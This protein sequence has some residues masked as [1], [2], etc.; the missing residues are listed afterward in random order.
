MSHRRPL[1]VPSSCSSRAFA[2]LRQPSVESSS[3]SAATIST[4]ASKPTG[5]LVDSAMKLVTSH[6]L[7]DSVN[8]WREACS[9]VTPMLYSVYIAYVDWKEERRK[10]AL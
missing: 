7:E 2:A 4:A 8:D 1:L 5:V 3:C 6:I 9:R 10:P